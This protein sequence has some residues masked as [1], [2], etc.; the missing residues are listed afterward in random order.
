MELRPIPVEQARDLRRHVLRPGRPADEA[1]SPG[2]EDRTALH[3]GVF[4]A[5][6]LAGVAS[7]FRETCPGRPGEVGWRLRGMAALE[8]ARGKGYGR[9][10]IQACVEYIGK[11][12]GGVLWCNGRTSARG[13]Y[14]RVGFDVEGDEFEIPHVGPHYVMIRRV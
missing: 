8:D 3:V 1:I 2:D 13:F 12:G 7:V 9:A 14:E 10:L 6:R 5:G 4:E 11:Q